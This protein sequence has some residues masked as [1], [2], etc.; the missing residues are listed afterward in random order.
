MSR[1]PYAWYWSCESVRPGIL[2]RHRRRL[3]GRKAVRVAYQNESLHNRSVPAA[4]RMPPRFLQ[5]T[6]DGAGVWPDDDRGF[7]HVVS[8]ATRCRGDG[9]FVVSV[10]PVIP[11]AV[12]ELTRSELNQPGPPEWPGL[13]A[14]PGPERPVRS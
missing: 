1:R 8:G 7:G 13:I 4:T 12:P 10:V 11:I 9:A 3:S 2:E 14:G 5:K 6:K